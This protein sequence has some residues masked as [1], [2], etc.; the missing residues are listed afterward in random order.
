MIPH[1]LDTPVVGRRLSLSVE[2]AEKRTS[3]SWIAKF[4]ELFYLFVLDSYL[5][6]TRA[7]PRATVIVLGRRRRGDELRLKLSRQTQQSCI[8]AK[9]RNCLHADRQPI[10][11]A[12][13]G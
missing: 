12:R 11:I 10:R 7:S 8:V 5:D 6:P 9:L 1:S 2:I 3:F 4:Q 13:Q